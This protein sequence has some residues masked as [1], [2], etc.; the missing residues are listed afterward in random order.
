[1]Q[2]DVVFWLGPQ[3]HILVHKQQISLQFFPPCLSVEAEMSGHYIYSL[4]HNLFPS[5]SHQDLNVQYS[6]ERCLEGP[7]FGT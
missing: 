6:R 3:C 2:I 5:A 1:M 4:L 7:S